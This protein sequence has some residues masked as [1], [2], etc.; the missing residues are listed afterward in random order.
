MRRQPC[1]V[2]SRAAI[3]ARW[4]H[5]IWPRR[6]STAV[7]RPANLVGGSASGADTVDIDVSELGFRP[8]DR[9]E[10]IH[11][12]DYFNDVITRTYDGGGTISVPMTSHSFAQAIGSTKAPV[13]Q[14]PL[15]GAFVIRR[16]SDS[17]P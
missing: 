1:S 6:R 13:S 15:F 7:G 3:R 14:F 2:A 9:Y 5:Q 11:A 4:Q 16:V 10:L 17:P 12:M 8:G